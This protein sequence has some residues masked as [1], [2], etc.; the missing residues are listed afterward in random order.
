MHESALSLI[1]R[2]SDAHRLVDLP[3]PE[4]QISSPE[5]VSRLKISKLHGVDRLWD[6]AS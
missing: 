6:T 1:G 2:F 5:N 3:T 4:Q